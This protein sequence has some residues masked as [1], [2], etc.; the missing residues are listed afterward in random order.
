MRKP[1]L[2]P[3]LVLMYAFLGL[4]VATTWGYVMCLWMDRRKAM[5][6]VG[7]VYFG[8][9]S[10]IWGVRHE[11]HGFEDLPEAIREGRQPVIYIANHTSYLDAMMLAVYLP[12]HPVFL[13]KIEMLLIPVLGPACWVGG[14][15]FI[16]RRNRPKAI[17]SMKA[18]ARKVH[19]GATIAAFPEGTRTR[20]GVLLPFKKGVFNLAQE[21][22]VPVVPLGL[23]GGFEMLPAGSWRVTPGTFR[24]HVGAP[25]RPGD[26][27]DLDVLRETAQAS[28]QALVAKGKALM[29]S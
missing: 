18:A 7:Q 3:F 28:V 21:A 10:R 17:E 6:R 19:G 27:A 11:I 1:F 29:G 26:F 23:T 13:A 2:K 14:C 5:N 15:I 4:F 25:I 20:D 12:S 16:N 8:H 9:M 24:I 22:D